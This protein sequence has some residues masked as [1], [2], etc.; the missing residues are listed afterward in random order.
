MRVIGLQAEVTQGKGELEPGLPPHPH[1][2][3]LL[4]THVN[5]SVNTIGTLTPESLG[6]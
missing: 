1:H 3:L 4:P 6:S 2:T 5:Y